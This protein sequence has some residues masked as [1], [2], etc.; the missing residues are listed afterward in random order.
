MEEELIV[1][2][3]RLLENDWS[4]EA[5]ELIFKFRTNVAQT[6]ATQS[7]IEPETDEQ[8]R[9][10]VE[11]IG[12][13]KTAI[14]RYGHCPFIIFCAY[15]VQ[16][17]KKFNSTDLGGYE[18]ERNIGIELTVNSPSF[19]TSSD[20]KRIS[21]RET[22]QLSSLVFHTFSRLHTLG[23]DT[24]P[25]LEHKGFFGVFEYSSPLFFRKSSTCS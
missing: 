22:K 15:E 16:E 23:S 13:K 4:Y 9:Q 17:V 14:A 19:I 7:P 21:A 6:T 8:G 3:Q 2:L 5:E 18:G 12:Q 20:L 10:V 24:K 11:F 25:I 1:A